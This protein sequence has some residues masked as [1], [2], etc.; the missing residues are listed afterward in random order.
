MDRGQREFWDKFEA[1]AWEPETLSILHANLDR[2][3]TFLDIGAWIGPT[4]LFAAT[5]ARRVIALEP[6]P[7]AQRQ[8]RRNVAL[9]SDLSPRVMMVDR[10]LYGSPGMVTLGSEKRGGDS[11]SSIM[12]QSMHTAWEV[13][14]ATPSELASAI[15]YE[16]RVFI[17]LDIE[18]SEYDVV[19]RMQALLGPSTFAVLLSLH[20]KLMIGGVTGIQRLRRQFEVAQMTNDLFA[21]FKGWQMHEARSVSPHRRRD[22]EKLV[23][24]GLCYRLLSG[25]W[26][27]TRD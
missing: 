24:W 7:L 26:L 20:P 4:T 5:R 2:R 6:D 12:H 23:R 27:F 8:L 10:A 18:G 13:S 19:P 21:T 17:K 3:T 15:E 11:K 1:S 16:E 9:N 22:I 14:T 25:T